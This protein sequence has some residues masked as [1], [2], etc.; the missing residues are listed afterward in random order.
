MI[1]AKYIREIFRY[2]TGYDES[3]NALYYYLNHIY[4]ISDFPKAT[5]SLRIMQLADV[6]LLKIVDL[7][8]NKYGLEYWIDSGTLLGAVRHKGFIPWDDDTDICMDRDNYIRAREILPKICASYGIDAIED[9]ECR[10]GRI[11]I[12]YKHK[13]T[14]IW[15]DVLP[16]NY[17]SMDISIQENRVLLES[18]VKRYHKK[19]TKRLKHNSDMNKLA[20]FRKKIIP[21]S[22]EK[23][24]AKSL[25]AYS[26]FW[27]RPILFQYSDIFPLQRIQFEDIELSCPKNFENYLTEEYGNYYQYP[28]KGIL[29]H[30]EGRGRLDSWAQRSGTDMVNILCEL[31]DIYVNSSR[32]SH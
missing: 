20:S 9:T 21:S 27:S 8:C 14:G 3:I 28:R 11:G 23:K 17:S 19:Y 24:D 6:K 2:I 1:F 16:Q 12:G 32:I 31:D 30:D 29:S 13:N 15:I 7:I 4:S 5:G 26:E 22:C 10:G 18:Q 25:I